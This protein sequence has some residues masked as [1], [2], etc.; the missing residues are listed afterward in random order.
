[1]D[2]HD[3][4]SQAELSRL[5]VAADAG[6]DPHRLIRRCCELTRRDH[7]SV[8]LLV[9]SEEGSER[10]PDASAP[11]VRLLG[12]A[13]TLLNAAGFRLEDVVVAGE[14]DREI[15]QLLRFGDFDALLV[16][17][18]RGRVLSPALSLAV[19]SARLQG[20]TVFDGAPQAGGPASW[21]RRLFDPL[22]HRARPGERAA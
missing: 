4:P 9:P 2:L 17:A 14:D 11:A 3:K 19:R 5:L 7:L 10:R 21:L 8:S 12:W 15:D 22:G 13:A 6:V 20:L 18:A 1:V 16:C